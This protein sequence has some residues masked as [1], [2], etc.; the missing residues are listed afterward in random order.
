[1]QYIDHT[2]LQRRTSKDQTT[3][4]HSTYRM[5]NQNQYA[6]HNHDSNDLEYD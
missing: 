5:A 3:P 2:Q 6:A 1:M 4:S